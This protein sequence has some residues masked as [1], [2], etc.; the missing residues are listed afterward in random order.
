[1]KD[2]NTLPTIADVWTAAGRI[3]PV[4][5]ETP[6]VESPQVAKLAGSSSVLLKL[7]LMQ[8]TGSF[9]VRGA[10]N[11]ILSLS[12][13]EKKRGVITF[14][15]GNH[16]RAVSY[17]AHQV[18]VKAVVCLSKRVPSYRVEA[19]RELGGTPVVYGASQDEAEDH[20]RELKEKEGYVPVVPF[21]DPRVIAGQGTIV[22]E[23]LRQRPNIDTLLIPL[24]GGGLLAGMAMTAKAL[25]PSIRVIGVSI[26]R[27]PAMLESLKI[28]KP[29]D[30]EEKDTLADSLLGGIGRENHYT[31]ELVRQ[32]VD[33]HI[34]VDEDDIEKGMRYLFTNHGLVAEGAASVGIG[35]L[36]SGKVDV[37]GGHVA[38]PL[39]GRNVDMERYL[40]IIQK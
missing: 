22:L 32:Y 8:P 34:L 18:G 7:E 28:G 37:T 27:S 13:E 16:G 39:T 35:A 19:I 12:D 10:T 29:A 14:S 15:T 33:E 25:K 23:L 38:M 20:Y 24:S 36:L 6:V 40:S 30:I 1:M 21:D 5:S 26:V 31:M 11:T 3:Y 4:V 17:V 9:K 2:T